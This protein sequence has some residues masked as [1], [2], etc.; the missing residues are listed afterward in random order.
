MGSACVV[1]RVIRPHS[2]PVLPAMGGPCANEKSRI[3][4]IRWAQPAARIAAAPQMSPLGWDGDRTSSFV[5]SS[6]RVI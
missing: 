1:E 5:T 3:A 6:R 2:V 4:V